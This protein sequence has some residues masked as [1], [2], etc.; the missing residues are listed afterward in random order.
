MKLRAL[1]KTATSL[2]RLFSTHKFFS[3][4]LLIGLI[5]GGYLLLGPQGGASGAARY[6]IGQA[7]KQT[8]IVSITG[9]GQVSASNQVDIKPKVSGDIVS[10]NVTEGQSVRAGA[11]IAQLDARDAQKAVRDAQANLDNANLSLQKLKKPADTLSLTQAENALARAVGTKE[12]A[13]TDLSKAYD[14][15]FNAVSNAFLDLPATISNLYTL[16]YTVNPGLSNNQQTIDY[17]ANAVSYYSNQ[18]STY[19]DDTDQKYRTTRTKYDASFAT[20]KSTSRF[21]ST[22]TIEGMINQTYET[23]K[24]ISEAIKSANNLIQFYSDK[25]TEN[26]RTPIALSTT[27][28]SQLNNY[29]GQVNTH[30]TALLN[31]VNAIK[32]DKASIL[33]ASRAITENMQSLDKLKSGADSLDIKTAELTVKQRENALSD[34]REQLGYYSIRAPFDGTIANLIAKRFDTAGSGSAIAS[35]ITKQQYAEISLNEVDAAKVKV[36][37]R[38][39]LTF[40]AIDGLNITGKVATIDALGTVSQGVV[41][42][43]VKIAFDTQDDRVKAGMTANASIITDMKQNTLAVPSSAVKSQGDSRYVEIPD[44]E[45]ASGSPQGVALQNPPRVQMV[46]V[47]ISNDTLIEIVT[48][49]SEGDQ[50]ITRT[51][52]SS[53]STAA[54]APSLFGGQGNRVGGGGNVRT[55]SR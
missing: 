37:Q 36:G 19:R 22:S 53:A 10:V 5:G 33:E 49:L 26:G 47:G 3:G 4:I 27:H 6:V 51:I 17:Y 54:T 41:T 45:V 40:D 13:E 35:L 52:N 29:T 2:R 42:Y 44:E 9:S 14:D 11:L 7:A 23:T 28:L 48:G 39:T 31:T 32:N 1:S 24:T 30:L 20:Y 50:V 43:N 8:V 46:E 21:S 16:L 15:G 18:A 34:V 38:A 12:T 25:L 55:F